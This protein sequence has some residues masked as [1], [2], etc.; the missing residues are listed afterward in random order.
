L[1]DPFILNAPRLRRHPVTPHQVSGDGGSKTCAIDLTL[2]GHRR[3]RRHHHDAASLLTG[4]VG[5]CRSSG[6]HDA[7]A[8]NGCTIGLPLNVAKPLSLVTAGVD[9]DQRRLARSVSF[10]N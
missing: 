8:F 1:S 6:G 5:I 3:R 2:Y 7:D 10:P 4:T 9:P